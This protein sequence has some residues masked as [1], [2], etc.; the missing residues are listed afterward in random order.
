[1]AYTNWQIIK[2]SEL[3]DYAYP[4]ELP[5]NY[6]LYVAVDEGDGIKRFDSSLIR[7]KFTAGGIMID[8]KFNEIDAKIGAIGSFEIASIDAETGEPDVDEP[9][10]KVIYLTRDDDSGE[11]DPYTEWIYIEGTGWSIIGETRIDLSNYMQK[12]AEATAGNFAS[13]TATG[14]VSDSGLNSTNFATTAQGSK[15]D[16][17]VQP[18]DL[19]TVATS[20]SYDDLSDKPS[21]VMWLTYGSTYTK[22]QVDGW[23]TDGYLLCVSYNSRMYKLG[24]AT[25]YQ[26][27]NYYTFSDEMNY[28]RLTI[29]NITSA[30]T[31]GTNYP[32]NVKYLEGTVSSARDTMTVSKDSSN[33]TVVS[34]GDGTTAA[35]VYVRPKGHTAADNQFVVH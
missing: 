12:V 16:T 7:V 31:D 34:S 30:W 3:E 33:Q 6:R 27:T 1:M 26:D 14:E 4:E 13:L 23:I 35:P 20:G 10:T 32:E 15:A 18:G 9:S 28:V 8:D 25:S 17:A 11:T 22:T 19:A 24:R 2:I 21:T 29:N 5:P